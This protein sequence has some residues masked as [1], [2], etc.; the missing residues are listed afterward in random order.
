M[1]SN[2]SIQHPAS[3][4]HSYPGGFRRSSW[5]LT[6]LASTPRFFDFSSG[7]FSS[8][9]LVYTKQ[10][11]TLPLA[12]GAFRKHVVSCRFV[13]NGGKRRPEIEPAS[14]TTY[15]IEPLSFSTSLRPRASK[16]SN[17]SSDGTSC[18]IRRIC[19]FDF[20]VLVSFVS[21]STCS[22]Q[23]S[24]CGLP[25]HRSAMPL[26][27]FHVSMVVRICPPWHRP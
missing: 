13:T 3:S 7:L 18:I 2:A 9:P 8:R 26:T 10:I 11:V 23:S 25:R 5:F 22:P 24:I 19:L 12:Y 14:L 20:P 16:K 1:R 6:N 15:P 4:W 17:A 21:Y 27:T